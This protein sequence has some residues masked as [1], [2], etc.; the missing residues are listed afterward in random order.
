LR[1]A[2]AFIVLLPAVFQVPSAKP[3]LTPLFLPRDVGEG[4]AFFVE[5]RN[6]TGATVSSGAVIWASSRSA[7]RIDGKELEELTGGQIGQGLTTQVLPGDAWKGILELPQT[8]PRNSRPV[9]FGALTRRIEFV[10]LDPGRHTIAV[11]CS[12]IWSDDAI[13][14]LEK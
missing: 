4:P 3:T 14:Y 10:P 1:L 9:A 7:I 6:T 13:F 2:I 12:G 8:A 5:C 11:R